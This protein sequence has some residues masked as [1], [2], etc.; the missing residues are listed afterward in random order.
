[1]QLIS[2]NFLLL[3]INHLFVRL[4][5]FAA[6]GLTGFLVLVVLVQAILKGCNKAKVEKIAKL[7]IYPL[8]C[9][10]GIIAVK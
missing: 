9:R 2:L 4:Q 7:T 3:F 10:V 1:L 8:C 6:T 5:L